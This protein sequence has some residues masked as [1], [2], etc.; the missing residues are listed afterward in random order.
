MS[1]Q[2]VVWRRF[3]RRDTPCL[4]WRRLKD[5]V[6]PLQ[7]LVQFED[8][9]NVATPVAVV[10]GGP[11]GHK[12]VVEHRL[13]SL[14]HQL[15]RPCNQLNLVR[16][17]ELLHHVASEE[18]TCSTRRQTP[19]V[20][21]LRVGPQQVAHRT[22]VRHLLLAVEGADLVQ[23]VD[24]RRQPSVHGQHLVL[25][26]SRQC[27]IVEHVCAVPPDVDGAVFPQTL[28]VEAVHLRDLTRLVVATDQLHPVRV[29]CLQ[30]QEEQERLDG[31]EPSVYKI[32]HEKVVRVRDVAAHTKQLLQVVELPV[33][34]AHNSDGTV[35][36]LHVRLVHEDF[37]RLLAQKLDFRLLDDFASLELLNVPVEVTIRRHCCWLSSRFSELCR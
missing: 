27:Q 36:N 4:L 21:V 23:C 17:V 2:E 24:G 19:S 20:D 7:M 15:V 3:L 8:G 34:V 14:H 5:L 29:P 26:E 25:D 31:V 33:D 1:S 11:H 32:A 6:V 30:G 28:V 37:P 10:G 9:C 16:R 22:V 12:G 18:V 13:V 35:H